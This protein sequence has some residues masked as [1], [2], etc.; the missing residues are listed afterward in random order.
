[1][2]TIRFFFFAAMA[3]LA[4]PAAQACSHKP[5]QL[6]FEEARESSKVV[7]RGELSFAFHA[8]P[9]NAKPDENWLSG[10]IVARE[11][12]KGDVAPAYKI[13]HH[14]MAFWCRGAGWEPDPAQPR[15]T[16]VGEFLLWRA[17]DHNPYIILGY[18]PE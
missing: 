4:A 17:N 7:V 16:Y 14:L 10:D 15:R 18:R 5:K 8:D 11:V 13:E 12:T 3:M 6:S 2:R 1:M 9:D